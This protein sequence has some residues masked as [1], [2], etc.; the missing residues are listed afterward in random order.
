MS[1][2]RF[3]SKAQFK[4]GMSSY[5]NLFRIEPGKLRHLQFIVNSR[6]TMFPYDFSTRRKAVWVEVENSVHVRTRHGIFKAT[7]ELLNDSLSLKVIKNS[8][9]RGDDKRHCIFPSLK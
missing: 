2:L 4:H 5:Q 1:K 3:L 8:L 6:H 9:S 7:K